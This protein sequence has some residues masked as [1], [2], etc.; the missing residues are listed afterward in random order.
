MV[1]CTCKY[2]MP[3]G[4]G[5]MIKKISNVWCWARVAGVPNVTSVLG[6][7]LKLKPALERNAHCSEWSHPLRAH[8]LGVERTGP[9]AACLIPTSLL[10]LY[11]SYHLLRNSVSATV[12]G[13]L[14]ALFH[15]TLPTSY[16]LCFILLFQIRKS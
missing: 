11:V 12:L 9:D 3:Q 15:F 2:R 14:P 7:A 1:E 6:A 13:E 5:G 4:W 10:F 8:C 16:K